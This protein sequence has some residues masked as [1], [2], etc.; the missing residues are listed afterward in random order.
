MS[1]RKAT[2]L[3]IVLLLAITLGFTST[4]AFAYW[5]TSDV[6]SNVT[7]NFTEEDAELL[8]QQTSESFEGMLVPKHYVMFE[9][10]V[11]QVVVTYEVGISRELINEVNLVVEALN[12]KIN[13]LD[14][15]S[16]LVNIEING[17]EEQNVYELFNDSV[18]VTIVVTIDEPIDALE[19]QELGL[20]ESL[21]NVEDSVAAY[22]A[23]HGQ[24]ITFDLAFSI[25]PK[26]E[27]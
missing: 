11:E 22:E 19:A 7:I 3:I 10:E 14:A 20:D 5:S 2:Q 9:G 13:D 16:H 26:I 17:S 12:I 25:E 6:T 15:Y 21:V 18:L 23:I 1:K 24:T 8:V 27:E 4:A